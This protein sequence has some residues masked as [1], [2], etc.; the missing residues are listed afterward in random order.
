MVIYQKALFLSAGH[1]G[2]DPKTRNYTTSGKQW[3][4][5][6]YPHFHKEG[7]FYEGVSNRLYADTLDK[8][9]TG[10]GIS[11]YKVYHPYEDTPLHTR[12]LSA[13][14]IHKNVQKGFY[15]SLH[16]DA[17]GGCGAKGVSA[18]TTIGQTKSDEYATII[19]NDLKGNIGGMI[20]NFRHDFSDKDP[21]KESNFY[22]CAKTV[23]PSVLMENNFFDN[24]DDAKLLI[25]KD[26]INCYC[27]SLLQ[28]LKVILK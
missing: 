7:N 10:E 20:S 26:Y 15:L 12:V 23:M 9:C 6:N 27:E 28:S 24:L 2:I 22:E 14:Y 8:M 1:G 19:L 3:N 11:V 18:F 21:D 13:N 5:E 4:H 17:C 16:S 25:D